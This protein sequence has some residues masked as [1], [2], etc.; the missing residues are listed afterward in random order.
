LGELVEASSLIAQAITAIRADHRRLALAGALYVRV[1]VA[2][3]QER[4]VEAEQA[5]EEGLAVARAIGHLFAEARLLYL[6]GSLCLHSRDPENAREWLVSARAIF[7]R[8]GA[9]WEAAMVEE[10]HAVLQSGGPGRAERAA[11][12]EVCPDLHHPVAAE[13]RGGRL[14]RPDRQAWAL[15]HLRTTGPLSP[16]A[17]ARALAVSVD[18][19]LLDLR[20]LVDAGLVR[21][22]G[23]TR[24]RRYVLAGESRP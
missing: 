1:L 3:K 4:W 12:V 5:L 18:T 17:Y 10:A 8:L 24:D 9:R 21:A 15:G 14:T 2:L 6:R 16:R 23:T 11:P 19:A 13:R 20:A 22:Q 7:Q